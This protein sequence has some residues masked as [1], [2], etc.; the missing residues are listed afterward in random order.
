MINLYSINNTEY[1][2]N[3]DATLQP[4]RCEL[5]MA[6]N[7][8][9]QLELELPYDKDEKW[10]LVEEGTVVRVTLGCVREQATVQQ[11]FRVYDYRKTLTSLVAIA[12]PVAME[13]TQD[14][15]IDNL[16]I[17]NKTGVEAMALLQAKTN[18]YTLYT[19]I[20][21]R[22][23]T[24]ISNSNLN[25]AIASG[26]SGCFIDVWGGE[27]VYDNLTYKVLS[28]I[29]DKN[30]ASKY[31]VIYGRNMTGIDYERDDSGMVTRIYPISSDGIR[32]N[33]NGYVDSP[34]IHNYPIIHARF[35]SAPYQ[36]VIDKETDNSATATATRTALAAIKTASMT[37][38]HDITISLISG[39][40]RVPFD[41]IKKHKSGDENQ[42]GIIDSVQA[43]ATAEIYHETLKSKANKAIKDGMTDENNGAFVVADKYL[44]KNW[45]WHEN[46]SVTP[47]AWWYGYEGD[48][49]SVYARNEY[50][51]I[52][53]YYEYFNDDGYWEE[54]K[55]IP[56]IDL[57]H[58][59]DGSWSIGYREGYYAHNEYVYATVDGTMQE[60]WYDSDGWYVADSSG[61]SDFGWHG[62]SSSGIWF[63][64]EDAGS[65]DKSKYL[66]DCWAFIDGTY[67]FFD[68][69]GYTDADPVHSLPDYPWGRQ[70]DEKTGKEWFGNT[71]KSVG[72]KWLYNQWI[73]LDGDYY[74]VDSEGYVRD[75]NDS[76]NAVVNAYVTG[77][78]SLKT[79]CNTQ[80]D[81]LYTLLYQQMTA[82]C[83]RQYEAGID[84]PVVTI[85][86]DMAD[87]S[88][89]D[90]YKDYAQLEK[91]CLGDVVECID[92]EHGINTQER[93][94]GLTYDCIRGYNKNIVIGHTEASLG[95]ILSTNTGGGSVPS[96]FDTSAIETALTT[97]GNA[98]AT[99]QN[100]KQDKLTAGENITIVNNV[101][102]ATGG[103][104]GLEYW[105]ETSESLY[106]AINEEIYDFSCDDAY[107]SQGIDFT[108]KS[109]MGGERN[110]TSTGKVVAA[111]GQFWQQYGR[112]QELFTGI[113]LIS[114]DEDSAK[115]K[116]N[117]IEFAPTT[118]TIDEHIVYVN[119][120]N[121]FLYNT[122][123]LDDGGLINTGEH[124][125]WNAF[126]EYVK[127]NAGIIIYTRILKDAGI[128]VGDKVVWGGNRYSAS[129][130]FP[131]FVEDNG[132]VHG[133][134]FIA[135]GRH[136]GTS[137]DTNFIKTQNHE[138]GNWQNG[139]GWTRCMVTR[140]SAS[141]APIVAGHTS[142]AHPMIIVASLEPIDFEWGWSDE[143]MQPPYGVAEWGTADT[144]PLYA[145]GYDNCFGYAKETVT[146][147]G[148]T[149][150]ILAIDTY[151]WEGGTAI[152]GV[153]VFDFNYYDAEEPKAGD[154]G[155]ALLA[156]AHATD[157]TLVTMEIA[158]E[159]DIIKYYTDEKT[160]IDIDEDG[161]AI[162]NEITTAAGSLTS[163]MAT[164][165][166]LLTA[167]ENITI[168]DNV[169]SATGGGGGDANIV[170][171]TQAEYDALPSSKLSDD[172][173]YMVYFDGGQ[174]LDPNYNYYKYGE[175]DEIVVR[176]YH[177]GQA[178][179]EVLWFF[180][181][182]TATALDN[183]IPAELQAWKPTNTQPIY[184]DS[185]AE[186]GGAQTSWVG[187]YANSIRSWNITLAT[188]YIGKV[189][190]VVNPFPTSTGQQ[191]NG[192]YS[193][194]VYIQ[195][196]PPYT[197][198]YFN[199]HEYT[200]K[201]TA[202]P[203][204]TATNTLN[205][206]EIDGT[207][208][209]ISGGGG[210]GSHSR[211]L[212]YGT[213]VTTV[214]Q[215]KLNDDISNYDDIEVVVGFATGGSKTT[216]RFDASWFMN[217]F[218][219]VAGATSSTNHYLACI[220]AT[221]YV[222]I[223]MGDSA[224]KLY[225]TE[226]NSL[227]IEEVYGIKYS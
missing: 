192:Y 227:M 53:K 28:Q 156:T 82:W 39:A 195:D 56:S 130:E 167:G 103:G 172:T 104:H 126:V 102:S 131:F 19:D 24:S 90:E 79:V 87:L 41:Y 61:A 85:R 45:E 173:L 33:G 201:V 66:H 209:G 49:D 182:W 159:G 204:G 212:L 62:D 51:K 198:I 70:V 200:H 47:H 147:N 166:N 118:T 133:K 112:T 213:N 140:I 135:K 114:T 136:K 194:Y 101:I 108:M 43:M 187:F 117:N 27:C 146:Y 73:K 226:T 59:D 111:Y 12:F 224:N 69:Y 7:G 106:R 105:I 77:L 11:R 35:M 99:L 96:G 92:S 50:I 152:A 100:G 34:I 20:T 46:T 225:M 221:Y 191:T 144:Y 71:D 98:I 32:L 37:P 215:F 158:T 222:R 176:V 169:I 207:V 143:T 58:N 123:I 208:Y 203:S 119:T 23:T 84:K 122:T 38:S 180:N 30:N 162:V 60:W 165:Q 139:N 110:Y 21:K 197:K 76:V 89:T 86:V 216:F 10:K 127:A 149:W 214:G 160:I 219:Y 120:A 57:Y 177:E 9:W 63:G 31:P 8:G 94:I 189:N 115:Y 217:S 18:K 183:S 153:S 67:Y 161:N 188:S 142:N 121:Y 16:A 193:P 5:T 205:K 170:E 22:G 55:R 13:S 163:Q 186:V 150:Y 128:G 199:N 145:G 4:L 138:V 181:N 220:Y 175:N 109:A 178:D 190:A 3:G 107:L 88:K 81:T 48:G 185:Y 95:S 1:S 155:L 64:E 42:A 137:G 74:Y 17:T 141:T 206:I 80:R 72:A 129:D 148:A 116:C 52:G 157:K 29:G 75:E 151:W 15:P 164:K 218:P 124:E 211:T 54:Y 68:Q 14:A 113:V 93:V 40:V 223:I 97:Q 210:G 134:K 26:E 91:I 196:S 154:A 44:E 184:S 65:E 171:L 125:S 179:Q 25:Y 132:I 168:V 36:L 174:T 78:A 2:K 83:N 6:I 202:N